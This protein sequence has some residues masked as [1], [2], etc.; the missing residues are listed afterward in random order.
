MS[1]HNDYVADFEADEDAANVHT[2]DF[3]S[4][5]RA[6]EHRLYFAIIHR[7]LADYEEL[8]LKVSN[9][10]KRGPVN[11]LELEYMEQHRKQ[12]LGRSMQT[13]CDI[14]DFPNS[15]LTKKYDMLD[16]Q[17]GIAGISWTDKAKCWERYGKGYSSARKYLYCN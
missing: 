16:K 9:L 8:C 3:I 6:P 13:Y 12:S 2:T 10:A 7:A 1:E 14:V 11:R 15:H 5:E 4:R 17:Y